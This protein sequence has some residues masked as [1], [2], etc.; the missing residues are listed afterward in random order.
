MPKLEHPAWITVLGLASGVMLMCT[1]MR[2]VTGPA[3]Y[4]VVN[5]L[6]A[7]AWFGWSMQLGWEH[8]RRSVTVRE[9]HPTLCQPCRKQRKLQKG[10]IDVDA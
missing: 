3:S 6:L 7:V 8:R 4:A 1:G 5:A 10:I 9:Y 2:L